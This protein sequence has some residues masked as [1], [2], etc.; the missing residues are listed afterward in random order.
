MIDRGVTVIGV[1][2]RLPLLRG[3]GRMGELYK[4]KLICIY[5]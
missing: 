3:T 1:A 5:V 4:F 2:Q